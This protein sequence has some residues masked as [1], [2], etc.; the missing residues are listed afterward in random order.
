MVNQYFVK[1]AS[2]LDFARLVCAFRKNPL[3]VYFFNYKG[4]Q[5]FS[6]RKVLQNSILHYYTDDIKD[7]RYISYNPQGGLE[8]AE[9]VDAT[10]TVS[11]YAPIIELD[12]LP[13]PIRSPKII[14]DKFKSAKVHDLGDLARLTYNPTL[15]EEVE[16]TLFSFPYKKKWVVGY[17]TEIELLDSVNCFN[18]VELDEEP[19]HPFLRYSSQEGKPIEFSN[20]IQHGYSFFPV[21]KFL[22]NHP[23]FGLK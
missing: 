16:P 23:I 10:K 21:V 2:F 1:T 20:K 22:Q 6:T 5:V 11:N 19:K 7:G 17:I 8:I 14:K 13:F 9:V 3:R 15:P 12:S 4:K 18:Y